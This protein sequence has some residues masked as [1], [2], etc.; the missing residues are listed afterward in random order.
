MDI[1]EGMKRKNKGLSMSFDV[2]YEQYKQIVK[3]TKTFGNK[4][5]HFFVFCFVFS[6][7]ASAASWSSRS[8]EKQKKIK[9]KIKKKKLSFMSY[10]PPKVLV[11]ET[12]LI[13]VAWVKLAH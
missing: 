3:L 7:G 12:T 9:N 1:N 13:D 2:K 6:G 5:S 10:L 8:C 4:R 11:V